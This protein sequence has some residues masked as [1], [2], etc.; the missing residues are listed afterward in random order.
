MASEDPRRLPFRRG[1]RRGGQVAR[2]APGAAGEC[3]APRAHRG[4]FVLGTAR[5]SRMS[6]HLDYARAG[7]NE[8]DPAP[9]ARCAARGEPTWLQLNTCAWSGAV[10]LWTTPDRA[11]P[12]GTGIRLGIPS[13]RLISTS[14]IHEP[15]PPTAR[16]RV[17]L[18]RVFSDRSAPTIAQRL[19]AQLVVV[20]LRRL[21]HRPEPAGEAN[22]AVATA[23]RSVPGM[24]VQTDK[25]IA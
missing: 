15:Q 17:D 18:V 21:T 20:G 5:S 8:Y 9:P 1:S 16:A 22:A 11:V 3:A 23:S 10:R 7:R 13:I 24:L 6:A 25:P 12:R 2:T 4:V 14:S 19:P